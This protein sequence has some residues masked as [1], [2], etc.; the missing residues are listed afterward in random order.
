MSDSLAMERAMPAA[1]LAG[2]LIAGEAALIPTDTLPALAA[3]PPH[4]QQIWV[5]KQ[6]PADKPLILMAADL[7]PLKQALGME[8]RPEWL[9]LAA[10][11]WPGALTLVLPARGS[12]L[13][14]LNP[15]AATLGIRIPACEA[16]REL[17]RQTGPL[18]TTSANRSGRPAATTAAEAAASFP[19]L[20]LLGPLPWPRAGGQASTV[21]AWSSSG[22]WRVLRAGA[23]LPPGLTS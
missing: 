14:L 19:Q 1:V 20:P 12:V 7:A 3:T 16:A 13:E 18:A 5:L 4:A 15:G 10:M 23:F 6:R 9:E 22:S 8:W 17:L 11:A 21:L 2:R